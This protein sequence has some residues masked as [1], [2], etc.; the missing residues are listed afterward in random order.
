MFGFL[1]CVPEL[2]IDRTYFIGC[3]QVVNATI[4]Q[5]AAYIY[6][7]WAGMS[8][9]DLEPVICE[10]KKALGLPMLLRFVDF[11]LFHRATIAP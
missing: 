9:S 4:Y 6:R 7:C 1:W 11:S 2:L 5:N 3:N 10:E 8:L